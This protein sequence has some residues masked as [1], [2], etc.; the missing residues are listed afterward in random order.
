MMRKFRFQIGASVFVAL[1][2]A[3]EMLC[4]SAAP[5]AP[6]NAAAIDTGAEWR[7]VNGDSDE[8]GYSGLDQITS[9]NAGRL[10][11]AWYLS[12]PGEASLGSLAD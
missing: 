7:N 6:P 4:S 11:L 12:L 1:L 9:A 3:G 2:A 8:T 10:R 5:A